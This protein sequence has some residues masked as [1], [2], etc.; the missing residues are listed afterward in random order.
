MSNSMRPNLYKCGY[1]K[2][3]N[4]ISDV[5]QKNKARTYCCDDCRH[6]Q[7]NLNKS[8]K[9]K[10]LEQHNQATIKSYYKNWSKERERQRKY[11]EANREKI[12]ALAKQY[13]QT[14][15]YK[16]IKKL[17][18]YTHHEERTLYQKNY[19]YDTR[20]ERLAYQNQYYQRKKEVIV[21]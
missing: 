4:L 21:Q 17:Y 13:Y 16:S 20:R 14:K 12:R 15:K 11:R 8:I 10:Q 18:Y 7:N 1:E 19:Y 2:C 6:K 9:K 3:D 5:N